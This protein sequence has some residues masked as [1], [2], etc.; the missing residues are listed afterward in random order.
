MKYMEQ[1]HF[2]D[3]EQKRIEQMP[4]PL[5]VYQ[6][7]N[8][9]VRILL[10][11]EGYCKLFNFPDHSTAYRYT[12]E[13][14]F[15]NT[16]PDDTARVK[17]AA[18]RFAKEGGRYEV[19]FRRMKYDGGDY[20]IIH[21]IGEHIY[22]EEGI[23]LAYVWYTDE[24]A[25]VAE[26][27][28][29]Q[30]T[31]VNRAFNT[32]LQE[33]SMLR[34]SYY[35]FLTGLPS[36]SY[37]FELASVRKDTITE[38]GGRPT[39]LYVDLCGMKRFNIK[40]GFAEGDVLLK[41]FARCLQSVFSE[42]ICSHFGADHFAVITSEQGVEEKLEALFKKCREL[43]GRKNLPV[44]VGIYQW[45]SET[46]SITLACDRAKTASDSL[47]NT[48]SSG[49]S[50]Y[51]Q[52]IQE[53]EENLQYIIENLDRAI[54][55]KWIKV[56]FQPIIR[57]VNGKVCDTEVLARW[58]DPEK[59]MLSP[60]AFIPPLEDAGLIH[61]LDL[62][63][64][65]RVLESIKVQM[66]DG[67]TV[68]PHSI[69]LSRSDFDACDVVEE[70][71]KRV[72]AAGISR[73]R[74]T[75]EIT[76]SV[77]GSDF[78]FMKE[79][80]ERFRSLGFPVWMDDFGSR[81]SSL[82]VLQSISFDLIKFDMSLT[83]RLDEGEAGKIILTEL[84]R[85]VASLGMDAVCEGVETEGQVRFLQEIGCS[86][87]QGYYFGKP[88]S[89]E[90]IR[91]LFKG[92]AL[93]DNENPEESEYYES[94]G[95][96][97]LFDLGVISG[98]GENAFHNVFES[99]PA[100][101]IE[102]KDGQARYVRSNRSYQDFVKRFF[103]VDIYLDRRDNY[104]SSVI[105]YGYNF[106]NVVKQCCTVVN[107]AFFD[108]AMPDG[109]MVHAFAHRINTNPVTGSVAVSLAVLS[110]SDPDESTT[111]A[112]IAQA[113]AADYY[114]IFLIDLDTNGYTEYSSKVG[115]EELSVVRHGEDFFES[116]R[117]DAMIRIYREDRE[118]FLAL[119]TKERVLR[120]IEKQGVFTIT[121]RLIDMG[122]PMYV[123][124]KINRLHGGNRIILGVSIIDAQM[125]QL[126]EENK[127]RQEKI[128]LGRIAAL[129]PEYIVLYTI[130]PETNN[131]T[132]YNPSKEFADFG[133]A[134]TGE[135]FFADVILDAP[136][137]IAPEDMERHL[138]VLTKE[139]MLSEIQKNGYFSHYYRLII[140]GKY[141]PVSLKATV[142]EEDVKKI[143]LGVT[144]DK[145]EEIRQYMK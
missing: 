62:Y 25:Y 28:G 75:I 37:F 95:R 77:I 101:I 40:Y 98:G 128:S 76:E 82:E 87:L 65:D 52:R 27:E 91:E 35:S 138:R 30:T 12:E 46:V 135:D 83:R 144:E 32:A 66:S 125:K 96:V 20:H 132:Q 29:S 93:I 94:I 23:R 70:I 78:D 81:Y 84:M 110:I 67:F 68:I 130:D 99:L 1:F 47:K 50:F 60:A 114:N 137:A 58:I 89:F 8:E 61:K 69:N 15:C 136:K 145:H 14:A 142:V 88:V 6:F 13:D 59:G 122:T 118:T 124:M 63:M 143:I 106:E 123:N 4:V 7:V 134:K 92:N 2:S 129:S 71:R 17:D 18:Y 97:N 102:V 45:Q 140:N 39:L 24:G 133:L 43:N 85:M 38:E 16:H 103:N 56:Y 109:S 79:Q 139:N 86:K 64:V 54:E 90:K 104:T 34:A 57:A 33:E 121:Y 108:E 105:K 55:E 112:D 131:Y 3:K 127:L 31:A 51:D 53:N 11:S 119:F 113:L 120:D 111:Y 5:A 126:E 74:I 117:R 10:L 73:D 72:D 9:K 41:E 42:D 80:V 115:G 107:S 141:V 21:G 100:A 44:H 48:Y 19:I 26:S 36:M 49:Y 22:T 116:A